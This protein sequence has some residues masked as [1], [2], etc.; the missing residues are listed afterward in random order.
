MLMVIPLLQ[1]LP[2]SS[3][4]SSPF[5]Q[6]TPLSGLHLTLVVASGPWFDVD[7]KEKLPDRPLYRIPEALA[8]G[9]YTVSRWLVEATIMLRIQPL[10]SPFITPGF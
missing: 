9:N 8:L 5:L 4:F 7:E 10:L 3:T 1:Q 6:H 2:A